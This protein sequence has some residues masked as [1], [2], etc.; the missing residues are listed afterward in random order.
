MITPV[1]LIDELETFLEEILKNYSLETDRGSRK[2]PQIVSGYLPPKNSGPEPDF[3]FVIVRLTEGVD[4]E[5]EARVTVKIIVGSYSED[6][7]QGWRDTANIIQHIW[8][9][10]FK[11]RIIAN[12]FLI[13]YPVRFEFPEEQPYPYWVGVMITEWVVA[14]P[15]MEVGNIY[16]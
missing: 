8:Q 9:E 6:T 4:K 5:D 1:L 15:V 14:K 12:R 16:E 10:L 11:C 3:P 13:E 2:E 7:Q